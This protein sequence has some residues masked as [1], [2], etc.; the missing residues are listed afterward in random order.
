MNAEEM[1]T[2]SK[3]NHYLKLDEVEK[4]IRSMAA[5]GFRYTSTSLSGRKFDE[6]DI[7]KLQD[8]GFTVVISNDNLKI[9]W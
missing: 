4:S 6:V 7:K 5:A 3:Q 8:G 9:T 2:L 1:R